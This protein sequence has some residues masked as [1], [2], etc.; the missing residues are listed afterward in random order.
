MRKAVDRA[1][2][3]Y[4]AGSAALALAVMGGILLVILGR[5]LPTFDWSFIG[6]ATGATLGSGGVRYQLLGTLVLVLTTFVIAAPL[7]LGWAL[8]QTIYLPDP[9]WRWPLRRVLYLLNGVPSILFGIFGLILFVKYL[10]WGKSWLAGGILLALMILPTVTIAWVERIEALPQGYLRA[11]ASLGLSRGQI[12]WSVIVPQTWGGG[13]SGA[14]LGLARAAG[15]TAP[16]MFT[17]AVFSGVTLPDGVRQSPVLALPYHIFVLAQDSFDPA[18]GAHLWA[19]AFVL[20]TLVLALSL[21][22]LPL[23]LR[24]GEEAT[25]G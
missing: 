22:A 24:A 5:G 23:R 21:L 13:V 3:L 4:C 17:A 1:L 20:L 9:R 6:S 2:M 12:V 14:L 8:M 11:A 19:A 15:E 10:G 16:I 25:H 7:A 18:A